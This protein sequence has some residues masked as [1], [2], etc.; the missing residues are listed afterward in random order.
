[1][2]NLRLASRYAKSLIDLSIEQGKLEAILADIKMIDKAIDQ[3]NE[4]RVLLKSPIINADKKL[5][6]LQAIFAGK[7]NPM[8]DEFIKILVRKGREPYLIDMTKEFIS[9]YNRFKHITPIKLT[10]AT[11]ADDATVAEII[12]QIKAKT[13]IDTIELH[14]VVDPEL[15]GGFVLQY[16]DKLFDASVARKL[17]LLKKEFSKNTFVKA[18]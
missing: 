8:M 9:Q 18:F 15:I 6:A 17:E 16:E 3:S 13:S 2:S 5:K 4:L 14:T 1:M 11:A 7:L 10:T 12:S